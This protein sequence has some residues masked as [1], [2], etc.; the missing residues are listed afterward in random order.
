MRGSCVSSRNL[1]AATSDAAGANPFTTGPYRL[2][3]L[4]E[5]LTI[6]LSAA[7]LNRAGYPEAVISAVAIVVGPHFFGL[8][9]AFR[10]GLFAAIGG[11]M[12][13]V[14]LLSVAARGGRSLAARSASGIGLRAGALGG[15]LPAAGLDLAASRGAIGL[16]RPGSP[17]DRMRSSGESL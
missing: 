11:A 10:S 2:A 16:I 17:K 4:F 3:V 13:A 5:V 14:G 7:M 1:P 12:V 9:P 15:S 8:I 6:T